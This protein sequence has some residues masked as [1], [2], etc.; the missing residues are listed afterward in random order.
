MTSA[1]Q[2][3]QKQ[4]AEMANTLGQAVEQEEEEQQE[5]SRRAVNGQ[6]SPSSPREGALMAQCSGP[7]HMP[8]TSG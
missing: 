7:R 2:Q 8:Q 4:L 3:V 1:L 6:A 5:A